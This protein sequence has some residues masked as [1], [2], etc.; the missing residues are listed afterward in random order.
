MPNVSFE[1]TNNVLGV[2]TVAMPKQEL[3]ER[4]TTELKGQRAKVAMKG[5]RKGKVPM[6][7]LRKMF[8]NEILGRILDEDIRESLFGY[9]EKEDI[10]LIFSPQPIEEEGTPVITAG[11]IEDLTLKYQVALEPEF[12]FEIPD[13]AFDYYVLDVKDEDIEEAVQSML[14]RAGESEDLTEGTVQDDD[15]ISVT[16][17]EAGPVDDK[18]TNATKIYLEALTDESKALFIGKS[19]GDSVN[20][21]DLSTLE[22][23]STEA[24]VK[25]YFL[26]LEDTETDISGKTFDVSVDGITRVT[27]SEMTTDFFAQYDPTGAVTTEGELR[28]DIVTKQSAGFKQQADG[29]AG[30][31]IQKYLVE[32]TEMELPIEMMKE[33]NKE[34]ET[35]YDLFERG[36]R[37][38]LIR[39]KFAADEDLKLEYED[40]REEAVSSLL[41]ML[42]GQRPD[43]LTEEF[44]DSYVKRALDDEEQRNQ[45]SSNA[46]EKKIMN[47]LREKVTLQDM[48]V[49]SD[50]FNEVIKKFNEANSPAPA[51]VLEEE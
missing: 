51:A 5:F 36:V 32:N 24:Y 47:A 45:L 44:I 8:G 33:I 12:S 34:D 3:T 13:T 43:F 9:I 30:F 21:A 41:G 29:M 10:K 48:P 28:D 39:N 2:I 16:F 50:K 40:I 27:P 7:T 37:W 18:I 20:V 31:A 14:K 6:G 35:E 49:D 25:K 19:V 46:I 26:D 17:T 23:D 4:L 1:K 22:K 11:N 42:G 38:M 15:V